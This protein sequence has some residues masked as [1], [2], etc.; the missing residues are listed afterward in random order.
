MPCFHPLQGYHKPGGGWTP[1]KSGTAGIPLDVPCG[2]CIGCRLDYTA[3]WAAR[4]VHESRCWPTGIFATL[5]YDDQNLPPNFS[6]RPRDT[7]LFW[8]RLRKSQAHRKIRYYL[9]GEYGEENLRPHYHAIIY[10][11]RPSD[12]KVVISGH[13]RAYESASLQALWGL[14]FVQYGDIAPESCAYV[15][16]YVTK[17]VT[18]SRAQAHYER[19]D[20]ESGVISSVLPEFSRSSRRPGIG[21]LH[22]DEFHRDLYPSDFII[23][24]GRKQPVPRY[25]DKQLEKA[26]PRLYEQLKELRRK[27]ARTRRADQTPER[28]AVRE[29]CTRAKL[30]AKKRTL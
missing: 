9:C 2:Q 3:Q 15:S 23:V 24:A 17:K 1:R 6:L 4:L 12:E 18:G 13:V 28:L 14:G 27:R 20:P 11:Y 10:N 19:M 8:K 25:Y 26:D 30:S 29:Q 7:E 22:Y 16:R 5:T 21:R